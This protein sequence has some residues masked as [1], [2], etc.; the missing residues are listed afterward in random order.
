MPAVTDARRT[1]HRLLTDGAVLIAYADMEIGCRPDLGRRRDNRNRIKKVPGDI[2][3]ANRNGN[4]NGHAGRRPHVVAQKP[5]SQTHIA[6]MGGH[7]VSAMLA[8]QKANNLV[9]VFLCFQ[10]LGENVQDIT[11]IVLHL[12]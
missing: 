8:I 9:E 12:S 11:L 5:E 4:G 3:P 10:E 1:F 6:L 7:N 2:H